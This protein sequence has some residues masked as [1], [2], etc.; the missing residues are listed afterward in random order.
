MMQQNSMVAACGVH[1][2]IIDYG[3][4]EYT[5]TRQFTALGVVL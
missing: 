2:L 5:Q 4:K 3:S 1:V